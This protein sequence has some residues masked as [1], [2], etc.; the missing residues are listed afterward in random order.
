MEG[1]DELIGKTQEGELLVVCGDL[2][3]HVGKESEGLEE[4]QGVH[5]DPADF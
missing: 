1:L 3:G 2:N 5:V 4:V